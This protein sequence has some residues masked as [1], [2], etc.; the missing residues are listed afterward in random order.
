MAVRGCAPGQIYL[1]TGNWTGATVSFVMSNQYHAARELH[2]AKE[3][4]NT[5]LRNSTLQ[6]TRV[7]RPTFLTRILRA[8]LRTVVGDDRRPGTVF[9]GR[10]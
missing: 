7:R 6:G 4:V 9:L 8:A 5:S 10:L 1:S 2:L 3:A